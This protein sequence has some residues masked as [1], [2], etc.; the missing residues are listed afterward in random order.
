MATGE[1]L[2][3]LAIWLALGL[4]VA[5]QA[6][7]PS[8]LGRWLSAGGWVLFGAHVALAFQ[9]HYGWSHATALGETA[10]QTEAM[11]GVRT[12]SGLYMNYLFG[13]VWLAEVW[14]WNRDETS[15]RSRPATVELSVRVFFLFML[16]NGAVIFV[17]APQRWVGLVLVV[18][19]LYAW[20]PST[21]RW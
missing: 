12:G 20:R 7:R 4:Y 13:L 5:S 9:V 14:W 21:R 8:R 16:V 1:L 18:M 17:D 2:T 15:Y 11:T 10:V 3:R 6:A 19:L